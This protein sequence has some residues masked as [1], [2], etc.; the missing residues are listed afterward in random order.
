[1]SEDGLEV[2]AGD[3]GYRWV[4]QSSGGACFVSPKL[5]RSRAA[6]RKAGRAWVAENYPPG[7]N[8]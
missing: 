7:G 3:Q 2:E 5:Y 8:L 6:A 4:Y 1:V